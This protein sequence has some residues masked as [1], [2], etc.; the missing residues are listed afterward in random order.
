MSNDIYSYIKENFDIEITDYQFKRDYIKEPLKR[1]PNTKKLLEYPYKEDIEYLYLILNLTRDKLCQLF[2]VKIFIWKKIV[3]YLNI[4]KDTTLIYENIKKGTLEKYGVENYTQTDEWHNKVLEKYNGKYYVETDDFK[5]KFKIT[6]LKH[7]GADHPVKS[8]IIKNKIK[9]T[10]IKKYGVENYTQTDEWHDTIIKNNNKKYNCDWYMETDDFKDKSKKTKEKL[11]NNKNYNNREKFTK[12]MIKKYKTNHA[13]RIN[14]PIKFLILD[15]KNDFEKFI[16]D[17]NITNVNELSKRLNINI[18]SLNKFINKY[19]LRSYFDYHGSYAEKEISNYINNTLKY[20]TI[21][22]SR[23]IISP[24]ELDIYIPKLNKA[25]EYNGNYWH[26]YNK[27]PEKE[28][29]DNMKIKLC[30]EKNIQLMYVWE[31]DFYENKE[32][33]L[34]LIKIFL[35]K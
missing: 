9:D 2:N 31:K 34:K 35:K 19:N 20:D 25:I 5:E 28:I 18:S 8:K 11:Y 32:K 33:C 1:H 10:N 30:K 21:N 24:Y 7:Y 29:R 26:D 14:D 15:N 17:N 22:N 12:T 3:K 13:K 6:S 16:I 23:K 4:K 27:F